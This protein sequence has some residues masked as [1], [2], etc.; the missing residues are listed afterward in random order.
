MSSHSKQ[1]EAFSKS[2]SIP[3]PRELNHAFQEIPEQS[4][5]LI[6]ENRHKNPR[7]A[8]AVERAPLLRAT[9]TKTPEKIAYIQNPARQ[10]RTEKKSVDR[11]E[12]KSSAHK[13][14]IYRS[15]RYGK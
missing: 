4:I 8:A 13:R 7:D 5:Q 15:P 12:Q 9:Q 1:S 10:Y 3:V 14:Y 2:R 11:L 6:S